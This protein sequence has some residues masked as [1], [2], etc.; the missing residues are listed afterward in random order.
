MMTRART[1]AA[2]LSPRRCVAIDQQRMQIVNLSLA[3]PA[4]PLL[5]RIVE[6]GHE[7]R[8]CIRRRNTAAT[9]LNTVSRRIS[10]GVIAANASGADSVADSTLFAPGRDVLTLAPGGRYDFMSGSSLAAAS[11]SGGVALLLARDRRLRAEDVRALLVRSTRHVATGSGDE[12]AS[13]NLCAAL[14]TLLRDDAVGRAELRADRIVCSISRC[15]R[16]RILHP[17]CVR[18]AEDTE[19]GDR[20]GSAVMFRT[21]SDFGRRIVPAFWH[22]VRERRSPHVHGAIPHAGFVPDGSDRRRLRRFLRRPARRRCRSSSSARRIGEYGICAAGKPTI[23]SAAFCCFRGARSGRKTPNPLRWAS[24][25]WP[26]YQNERHQIEFPIIEQ[27][28]NL[29]W[30]AYL[31]EAA[32]TRG[33]SW[34]HKECISS[35]VG[36]RLPCE[37]LIKGVAEHVKTLRRPMFNENRIDRI[38]PENFAEFERRVWRTSDQEYLDVQRYGGILLAETHRQRVRRAARDLVHGANA[39]P[40]RGQQP[41]RLRAALSATGARHADRGECEATARPWTHGRTGGAL[42]PIEDRVS[43]R[44]TA[45]DRRQSATEASRPARLQ[46]SS[47]VLLSVCSTI[48]G[49][50]RAGSPRT[51]RRTRMRLQH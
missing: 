44:P 35:D 5:T 33:L 21:V 42:R 6:V 14:A 32:Y 25:Y 10:A 49:R 20:L 8:R 46:Y 13:V 41:A 48:S 36:K 26:Y 27:I 15:T 24:Y 39:V 28:D 11:I 30:N 23:S 4:D 38:W 7:T 47:R 34:P 16:T 17:S 50:R 31:Q 51:P 1:A 3:G 45:P 29:L 2:S 40:H 18:S 19:P 9:L 12:M 43:N 37:M 22:D